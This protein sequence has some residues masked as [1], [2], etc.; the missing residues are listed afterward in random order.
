MKNYILT[1]LIL[2]IIIPFRAIG[3]GCMESD[4]DEGVAVVGYVQ[5][6]YDN[7]FFDTDNNGNTLNK[8]NSFYFKRAR[9]GVMGSIPYD[10]SYY[11][12]AEFSPIATGNPYLLDAFITYAPFKKYLKFTIGQFKSPVGLE[13]NTPC[14]ALYTIR[15]ST[16]V[17]N[18]ATPFR[19]MQ[20]MLFGSTD[21]LFGRKDLIS[22]KISILNGTGLNHWDDNKFKDIAARLVISPWEWLKIGGSYRTGK[23][24]I[25]KTGQVQK[26]RTRYGADLSFELKNI[27][28]QAEYLFGEDVGKVASGGGCGGKSTAVA[29]S[30]IYSK[31]GFFVM[32]G[33]M[34]PWNLQ[35]IIKFESYNPHVKN[36]STYKYLYVEQDFIQTTLTFGLNYF[37][38]D[39]TRI[40]VNYLYNAEETAADEFPNDAIMFQIQ[41]KF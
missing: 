5:A 7:Y 9:I 19:D 27:L 40:Q 6:D 1:I 29:D 12:M 20:F 23:Q 28:F 2:S 35:P 30:L 31:S 26:T 17:N 36:E 41:A 3:Q 13:L 32:A 16:V 15:R 38:N 37:L 22:Y 10:V 34:T 11:V 25:K 8:P 4:S 21:S 33:Y 14:H 24:D 39:W 18:L